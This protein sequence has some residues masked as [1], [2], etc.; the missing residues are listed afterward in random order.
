[1]KVGDII[2]FK[3]PYWI[4]AADGVHA[5]DEKS[6]PWYF[7]LLVEFEDWDNMSTVLYKSEILR[8]A[9]R[10]C[11]KAGKKDQLLLDNHAKNR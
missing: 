4:S 1:M 9:S 10:L 5:N 3:P 7:G 11:E 6:V 2:R 8:I